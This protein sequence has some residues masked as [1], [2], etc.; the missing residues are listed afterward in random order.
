MC[1]VQGMKEKVELLS[2]YTFYLCLFTQS[3]HA[4]T[5]DQGKW[6]MRQMKQTVSLRVQGTK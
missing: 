1:R 3:M 4:W 2:M 6:F 5:F